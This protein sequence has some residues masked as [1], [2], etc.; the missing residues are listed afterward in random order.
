MGTASTMAAMVE[1][2]GWGSYRIT[3]PSQRA[4]FKAKKF[5]PT[6]PGCGSWK[7]SMRILKM[8]KIFKPES[9]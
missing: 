2:L 7:W 4:D 9:L 5:L 3:Q 1:A 6:C 8:S